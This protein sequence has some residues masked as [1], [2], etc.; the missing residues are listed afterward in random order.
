[1]NFD[2]NVITRAKFEKKKWKKRMVITSSP[3][4]SKPGV[5]KKKIGWGYAEFKKIQSQ[6]DCGP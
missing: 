1:M 5:I 4:L 3:V 2:L 6:K